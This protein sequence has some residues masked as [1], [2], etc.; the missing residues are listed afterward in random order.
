LALIGAQ[1][2]SLA[3]FDNFNQMKRSAPIARQVLIVLETPI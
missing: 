1:D 2:Y 3:L